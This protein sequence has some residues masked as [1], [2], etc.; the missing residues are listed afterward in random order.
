VADSNLSTPP[1]L[2]LKEHTR[3]EHRE[4]EQ[5]AI[6]QRLSRGLVDRTDYTLLLVT[7]EK[8]WL[9]LEA[10]LE[11][12]GLGRLTPP[13][14][15]SRSAAEDLARLGVAR[16]HVPP[17]LWRALSEPV[18]SSESTEEL[19]G[20]LYVMEGSALGNAVLTPVIERALGSEVPRSYFRG[21]GAETM[22]RFQ[23]FRAELDALLGAPGARERA[24]DGAR[25]QFARVRAAFE[26]IEACK[27]QSDILERAG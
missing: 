1:S 22:P 6:A 18:Q 16:S 2:W 23:R 19:V 14:T 8:L 5:A 21:H 24:G 17:A 13:P 27:D 3:K 12:A 15:K 7:Y 26:V 4:T 20:R 11:V 10:A 25:A 9:D